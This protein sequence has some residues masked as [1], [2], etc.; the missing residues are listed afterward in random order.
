[1]IFQCFE[2]KGLKISYAEREAF[3]EG[4]AEDV[5]GEDS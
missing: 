3:E 4:V 5:L 2:A 1:M